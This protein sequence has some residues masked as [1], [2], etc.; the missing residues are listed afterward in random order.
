MHWNYL[1][2]FTV[3]TGFIQLVKIKGEIMDLKTDAI[4]ITLFYIKKTTIIL[5]F[6]F[7]VKSGFR[8]NLTFK[9]RS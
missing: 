9:S 3:F 4:L 8:I 2:V 1:S 7:N 6:F 5:W